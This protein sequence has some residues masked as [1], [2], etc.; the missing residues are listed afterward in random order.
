MIAPQNPTAL[1]ALRH[2][3]WIQRYDTFM[4]AIVAVAMVVSLLLAWRYSIK[5]ALLP[6]MATTMLSSVWMIV[7]LFRCSWFVLLLM[8]RCK[9]LPDTTARHAMAYVQRAPINDDIDDGPPPR[10]AGAHLK[11]LIAAGWLKR[12]DGVMAVLVLVSWIICIY[13]LCPA[14]TPY[15]LIESRQGGND[16]NI[17]VNLAVVRGGSNNVPLLDDYGRT[18]G[19]TNVFMSSMA[20]VFSEATNHDQVIYFPPG[21]FR[22]DGL[23]WQGATKHTADSLIRGAVWGLI[24]IFVASVWAVALAFRCAW[25]VLQ[26]SADVRQIPLEAMRLIYLFDRRV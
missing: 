18:V 7:L 1:A 4:A 8:A 14:G 5:E 17:Y 25:F 11:A 23:R 26:L 12:A 9:M 22:L 19:W 6:F 15:G 2:F 16:T 24:G 21:I 3:R 10:L 20:K 13:N